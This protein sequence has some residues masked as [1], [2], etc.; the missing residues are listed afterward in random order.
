MFYTVDFI[1]SLKFVSCFRYGGENVTLLKQLRIFFERFN[2]LGFK[3]ISFYGNYTSRKKRTEWVRRRYETVEKVQHI[4]KLT[5]RNQFH[6]HSFQD[7]FVI[8]PGL[9]FTS[10]A[11]I[12]NVLN[13]KVIQSLTE[14]DIEIITYAKK[15]KSFA[16]MS[17]DTDFIIANAA[18]YYLS[19]K[20][21]N[22]ETM[23]TYLYDGQVLAR[24]HD[25][26]LKQLPLFATILGTD[27]IIPDV[28][29][30]YH[31]S[32]FKKKNG[33]VDLDYFFQQV[34]NQCRNVECDDNCNP[35][36]T[37]LVRIIRTIRSRGCNF[38]FEELYHMM[39]ASIHSFND[40][41]VEDELYLHKIK[42]DQ[43]KKTLK[44]ALL[45]YRQCWITS[46]LLMLICSKTTEMS[47]CME[48]FHPS[49]KPVGKIL[50]N[51]RAVLY[52]ATFN[53]M[54]FNMY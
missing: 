10:T 36:E 4:I 22:L 6:N 52:S 12:K 11:I 16:I 24:V 18:Q 25:L 26:S 9:C 28:L 1:T 3:L 40:Y 19:A 2:R 50:R 51:L 44:M 49:V 32:F 46:D 41:Q 20:H 45:L 39:L 48:I 8:P 21:L 31:S 38:Q 27:L 33:K 34:A 13:E 54:S 30:S 7:L 29:R 37:D 47:T 42:D 43:T 23:K 35:C 14:N 5:D 17:Q 53:G 15:N